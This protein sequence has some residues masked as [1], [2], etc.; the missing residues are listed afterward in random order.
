MKLQDRINAA[1]G[2]IREKTDFEPEIALVL[3]SGLGDYANKIENPIIIKYEDIPDFPRS[4]VE[5]HAGRFV[6]GEV[7]GK[8]VIAMQGRFHGYEGYPQNVLTIP[9]R[10]MAK[11][12]VKKLLLTNAAGGVNTSYDEGSLMLI[13]DHINFSGQNPLVGENLDEFGPRFPDMSDIYNAGYREKIREEADKAGLKLE[14]GVYMIL[15]GP[16]Y[17]TPAEIRMARLM[18][19]DAVGMSTVPE[20]I[21]ARHSGLDVIGISCITN[22]AAGVSEH[23]LNHQEVIETTERVKG[24]FTQL[25]DILIEKVF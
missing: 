20:A 14:E 1:V 24:Q 18:G 2:F 13:R 12:G 16:S 10:V 19:A 21:V 22:M 23:A 4:T 5:G 25:L 6:M 15:S 7:F 17:E 3:G 11:L 9:I 8:K